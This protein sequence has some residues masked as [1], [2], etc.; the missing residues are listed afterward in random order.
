MKKF[1][2]I[3]AY[4]LIHRAFHALPPLTTKS[5][6][7]VN[8]VY[9][10]S[11][12]LLKAIDELK[13]DY[14][15]AAFDLPEPTF[16]HE[17]YKE[18]KA[19][20]PEAPPELYPQVP[21]VK[22]VLKAL[23]VPIYEKSGYEA[24]D[25]IGTI[26]KKIAGKDIE[27][28]ILTGDMDTLQLV[29]G[30]VKVYTPKRGLNDPVIYDEKKV[31]ERFEGLKPNQMVDFKGLK[32][33]P[34]D[35]IPGVRGI[36]EKTAINLLGRYKTIENLYKAVEKDEVEGASQSVL[37][38]L[39]TGKDMAFFS[40]KLSI[41]DLNVPIE[42]SL[43]ESEFGEPDKKELIEVFRELGFTRLI[44][45]LNSSGGQI[46]QGTLI[47]PV[48][49]T[50]PRDNGIFLSYSLKDNGDLELLAISDDSGTSIL[51]NNFFRQRR[52]R[53]W[54]TNIAKILSDKKIKKTCHDF[55]PLIKALRREGVDLGGLEFDAFIAAYVLN[56]GER[57]YGI[58]KLALK[59]FSQ[60][61]FGE[62]AEILSA[63][64]D[65][66]R[67]LKPI[68]KARL[69][70]TE[71]E[72]IF[73]K[74][75]MPL[76]PILAKMEET[77]IKLNGQKLKKIS[78][79][80]ESGLENLEKKIHELAGEKFNVNSPR[81]LA[82]ILFLKL[83]IP[84]ALKSGRIRKTPGGA[85]STNAGE[86]EKLRTEH[87]II[88]EILSY[89]ELAKL[90]STY[91]DALPELADKNGRVHTT[92]NQTGTATGRLSSQDPNLQNIPAH[93]AW[94]DEIRASFV[95]EKGFKLLSVDY[96]QIQLRIIAALA[97]DKKMIE[98]FE[99]GL[100]IHKFTASEINNVPLNKV[101]SEMRFAAKELNF[102]I[103]FGMGSQSFG[104]SAG[105][106]KEQAEKFIGEYLRDFSGI[107]KYMEKLKDDAR[108][109]G[110][111]STFFGRRRYLPE[112]NSPNY[113][114]RSQAERIAINMPIQGLEADIIKKAMIEIDSWIQKENHGGDLR[115]L[116]Q[117]HD[118]LLFEVKEN[119]AKKL[120]L[121]IM[122]LMSGV[123]KLKVP[124]IAGAKFGD[125]WTELHA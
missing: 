27:I 57:D 85:L 83:K 81:Q 84:G 71:T 68:L 23:G 65:V 73:E 16:R 36:G 41:L 106:S 45:R 115:L 56:P 100:D 80:L 11:S 74:I 92:F 28:L 52:I 59:E 19:K 40:K 35:N 8:A 76:I 98:A 124:I 7:I 64:I 5:G 26:T 87:K 15:A 58:E 69:A 37:E 91:A 67:R 48:A 42:F 17:E 90:K 12:I 50:S 4:A 60:S 61:F 2:L 72:D 54:R 9:G 31:M 97:N 113:M 44:E 39:K 18:Y 30:N 89:R 93:G 94:G 105:I 49:I 125:N 107:A 110:F 22:E 112:L 122:E 88:G 101:T 95:A 82:N 70:A 104:E 55:K 63:E 79:R 33:D 47:M 1:I 116:L 121:K 118:E 21:R 6:E 108:K 86:L 3:D 25:I 20:R 109:S 29:N 75:E 10:F 78:K 99:K 51:E 102:G 114:L 53:L 24:D 77:G 43:K 46:K 34:S 66:L 32:G 96:S 123:I 103:I 119:M 111:A 14:M 120:A 62:P 117:V 13:P 38:K